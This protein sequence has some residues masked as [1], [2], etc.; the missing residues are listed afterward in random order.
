MN[1]AQKFSL[2]DAQ[3]LDVA[4]AL[5]SKIREGLN[6]EGAE[7]RA[8]PSFFGAPARGAHGT[9]LVVDTGGTNMRAAVMKLEGGKA[10][11]V[12]GPIKKTLPMRAGEKLTALEFFQAQAATAAGMPATGAPVGYCFSYPSENSPDRD[13]RLLRWT[14][15]IDIPGVPGTLVGAQ[16]GQAL[17]AQGLEIGPVRVL[18]DTVASMLGGSW[19]NTE[20]PSERC[21][22]LIVGT[23]NN[24]AAYFGSDQS[25]K[26]PK[27]FAGKMAIN[28]ESGNFDP[29]H[30][31]EFDRALDAASDNAGFQRFEKAVS[32]FY[33]PFLFAQA[34]PGVAGFDPNQGTGALVELRSGSGEASEL[35]RAILSRSADLVAAS[36]A[37]VIA[38]YPVSSEPVGILAEG[39]LF[40]NE[41]EYAPRVSSTLA[42]LLGNDARARVLKTEEAN[43]IGSA[44]AALEP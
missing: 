4:R 8:L 31:N 11:V 35:A 27:G 20:V 30:L 13:S 34:L 9:A 33:L 19:V 23:G 40:W 36:L 32:G 5:T 12:A 42:R 29:P 43:L 7:I 6:T 16:L 10:E 24:M 26:V 15:G 1:V 25:N 28:L 38:L 17:R 18:N 2:S 14:K 21:I 37:G 39:G 44:V 22:G 41:P 3:L